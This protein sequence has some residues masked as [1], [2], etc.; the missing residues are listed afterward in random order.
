M[1]FAVLRTDVQIP[2]VNTDVPMPPSRGGKSW[3]RKYPWLELKVGDSFLVEK[4]QTKFGNSVWNAEQRYGIKLSTRSV[5]ING[6]K[7]TRVWR[8]A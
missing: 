4:P 1:G 7:C 2:T 8:V 3:H 6:I 5:M